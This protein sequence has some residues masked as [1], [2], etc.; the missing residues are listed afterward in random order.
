MTSPFTGSPAADTANPPDS[1]ISLGG[2]APSEARSAEGAG[3]PSYAAGL[4]VTDTDS[5]SQRRV[6][7]TTADQESDDQ[8]ED[9][10]VPGLVAEHEQVV[11]AATRVDIRVNKN[12]GQVIGQLYEAV[13]R[14][15]GAELPK[16]YIENELKNYVEVGSE[17]ELTSLLQTN[18]VLVLQAEH[19]G[20]GRWTTAL[21]LLSTIPGPKLTI[22]RIRRESGDSLDMNGLRGQRETG[23]I[24]DLRDPD[25]NIPPKADFD[26]EIRQ[27]SDLRSDGSYLVVLVS[28]T[29]WDRI[30]RSATGLVRTLEPPDSFELF[31]SFLGSSDI[32]Y[33]DNW[34]EKFEQRVKTLRP[35]LVRTWSQAFISSHNVFETKNGRPPLPDR[36]EDID[37]MKKIVQNAV[38][39]WMDILADW[40]S[41]ADRTSYE[42]NY[43][44]LAAVYGG[45]PIDDVHRK[46]ASLAEALGERAQKSGPL[47]G[48]QGPGLVQL[49]RQINAALLPDGSLR[50]PGPGFAEAVVR[51][52]WLDRP[53]LTRDF[54]QWTT[55]LSREL[56]RPEESQL[57]EQL[58]TRMIPWVL[59]HTQAT[60]SAAL[61]RLVASEWSE[62]KNLA[63]NAHDLLVMA[64]LDQK[65]GSRSR[66]AIGSWVNQKETTAELLRTLARVFGTL[67]PAHKN[68]L[69]RLGDLAASEMEGV[70]EAVGEAIRN[71]WANDEFRP[72]LRKKLIS[73]F[74]IENEHLRQSAASAFLQLS[75][76]RDTDGSLTLLRELGASDWV[77]LGWRAV[78]DEPKP[79][80][81]ANHAFMEWLD[82]AATTVTRAEPIFTTLVSA[83]HDTPK[84]DLRGTRYLNLGRLGGHWVSHSGVLSEPV[85]DQFFYQLNRRTQLADPS[86]GIAFQDREDSPVV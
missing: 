24:L 17:A 44:L 45:A 14:H 22:R 19:S 59:H 2:V 42:R 82:A 69:G 34:A 25:E 56:E 62:S 4:P 23:W 9:R 21:H 76:Q 70:P 65:V 38:S 1:D 67:T 73:W 78:L 18:R 37:E 84:D 30:G 54:L 80:A 3:Q 66:R 53:N 7:D 49:A 10:P 79:G 43:L 26:H 40:H 77:M 52:F 29:L 33:S 81:L 57:A 46:I 28:S 16:E 72:I 74:D 8:P 12:D 60:S 13:Q 71:L 55:R 6:D 51:Y 47:A 20:T 32:T 15:S 31:R 85:R 39:E 48:Q 11:A 61:L 41:K 27:V 83:I 35:A 68:F 64:C 75:L 5:E 36:E 86:S 58:A 63:T 50:F